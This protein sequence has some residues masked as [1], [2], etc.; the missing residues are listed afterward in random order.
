MDWRGLDYKSRRL[1][2]MLYTNEAFNRY[3]VFPSAENKKRI[4]ARVLTN[5]DDFWLP[6]L[7][8]T[9]DHYNLDF[10]IPPLV[11]RD[12]LSKLTAP[13]YIIAADKDISFPGEKLIKRAKEIFPNFVGSY[14]LK[15]SYHVP[16]FRDEDR[17]KFEG[18]FEE[19]IRIVST[20]SLS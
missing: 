19:A 17:K 4:F 9:Q 8:D 3:K 16:S 2:S 6:Y 14:L 15:D 10:S 18:L 7:G 11:G 13:V 20:S 1:V 12:D 5:G